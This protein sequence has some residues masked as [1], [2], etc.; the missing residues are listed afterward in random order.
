M[1]NKYITVLD[2]TDGRVYQYKVKERFEPSDEDYYEMI[3]MEKGHK[4]N[5]CEWMV[6]DIGEIVDHT[7]KSTIKKDK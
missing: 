4:L 6:H 5:N 1:E 2:F 7:I 3:I